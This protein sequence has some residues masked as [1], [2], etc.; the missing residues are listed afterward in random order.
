M[1]RTMPKRLTSRPRNWPVRPPA[2][3][4]A[5]LSA[6]SSSKPNCAPIPAAAP[7]ASSSVD[8]S[9]IRPAGASIS[10]ATCPATRALVRRWAIWRRASNAICNGNRSSPAARMISASRSN[11]VAGSARNWPLPMASTLVERSEPRN[12]NRPVCCRLYA[13]IA[14]SLSRERVVSEGGC[15]ARA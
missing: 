4:S 9:S 8:R 5:A 10:P 13:T 15:T 6:R 12:L 14:G 2:A 7:T 11:Q 3:K 1:G